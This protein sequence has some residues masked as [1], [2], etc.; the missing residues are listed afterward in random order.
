MSSE[1]IATADPVRAQTAV[2][3]ELLSAIDDV[4]QAIDE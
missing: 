1:R 3:E 4:V 2:R